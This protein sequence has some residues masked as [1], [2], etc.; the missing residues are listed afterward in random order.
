MIDMMYTQ[1]KNRYLNLQT[2]VS[3]IVTETID[4]FDKSITMND[5]YVDISKHYDIRTPSLKMTIM[6][7]ISE[8][9]YINNLLFTIPIKFHDLLIQQCIAQ[10]QIAIEGSYGVLYSITDIKITN[11]LYMLKFEFEID[12]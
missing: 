5:F 1:A 8:S 2:V 9:M 6:M 12:E 3:K 7:D 4:L 11:D 10:L